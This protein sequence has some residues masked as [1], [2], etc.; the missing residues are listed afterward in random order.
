MEVI[1]YV[2]NN[3]RARWHLIPVTVIDVYTMMGIGK[4][5]GG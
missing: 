2:E 4:Q 3:Y 5:G 1:Q